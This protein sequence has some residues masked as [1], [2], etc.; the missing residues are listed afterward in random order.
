MELITKQEALSAL[1]D[2]WSVELETEDVPVTE[3][4]GRVLAENIYAGYSIP[5]NRAASTTGIA[6]RSAD[7]IDEDTGYPRLPDTMLWKYG[8]DYV[9]V[10]SGNDF[11]D[12]FDAVI[13]NKMVSLLPDDAGVV[14]RLPSGMT[15][16]PDTN[17]T[18]KASSIMKGELLLCAGREL[19]PEEAALAAASG[20]KC[21]KCVRKPRVAF[22]PSGEE[23]VE[24]GVELSRGKVYDSNSVMLRVFLENM[25]AEPLIFPVVR[26]ETDNVCDVIEKALS[27]ADIVVYN[28]SLTQCLD[29]DTEEGRFDSR[30]ICSEVAASPGNNTEIAVINGKPAIGLPRKPVAALYSTDWCVQS[31]VSSMLARPYPVKTRVTAVLKEDIHISSVMETCVKMNVYRVHFGYA[32]YPVHEDGSLAEAMSANG[33]FI[34]E[35]G[36]GF[37][38]EGSLIDVELR[39]EFDQ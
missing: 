8:R 11:P 36:R 1:Y 3:C 12:E 25:G 5:V 34:T 27:T 6:V 22:I 35:I 30:I 17:V 20:R 4:V 24:A 26:P 9:R 21:I 7:F 2:V 39:Y 33:L 37:Y 29:N 13:D 15:V 19:I 18:T 16:E 31:L 10:Y 32:A 28:G 38:P 14:I 23:L